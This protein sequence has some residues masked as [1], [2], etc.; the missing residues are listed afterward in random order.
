MA[1]AIPNELTQFLAGGDGL[2][3][4]RPCWLRAVD[5]VGEG[6]RLAGIGM[7]VVVIDWYAE[8]ISIC[9]EANDSGV[10]REV[11]LL[12]QVVVLAAPAGSDKHVV[13][14]S[15]RAEVLQALGIEI[16]NELGSLTSCAE[17]CM[18]VFKTEEIATWVP[19]HMC[20]PAR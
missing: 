2:A 19:A 16:M 4:L 5:Q 11:A 20:V 7:A 9:L 18:R 3:P 13:W 14:N 10:A 6:M 12:D 8:S 1:L 15:Q 17:H